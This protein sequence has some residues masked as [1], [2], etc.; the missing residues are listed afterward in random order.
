MR[1]TFIYI[2]PEM[3]CNSPEQGKRITDRQNLWKGL[4]G[5]GAISIM[6]INSAASNN[7]LCLVHNHIV[8]K[9]LAGDHSIT[10]CSM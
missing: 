9:C 1:K 8:W 6:F 3:S 7:G 2:N 5:S 10:K 4:R